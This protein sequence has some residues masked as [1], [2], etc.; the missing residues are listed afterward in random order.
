MGPLGSSLETTRAGQSWGDG[1]EHGA[2]ASEG[3][4]RALGTVA[5]RTGS[6]GKSLEPEHS[7]E[8]E[9]VPGSRPAA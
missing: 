1:E 6:E 8:E 9:L 7:W 3:R 5:V 2:Q 4:G